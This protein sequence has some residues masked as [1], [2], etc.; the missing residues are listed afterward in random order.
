MPEG[1]K[2]IGARAATIALAGAAVGIGNTPSSSIHSVARNP[3]LAKQLSGHAILGWEARNV[4]MY[5]WRTY[6]TY[7]AGKDDLLRSSYHPQMQFCDPLPMRLA[8]VPLV[9]ADGALVM[10]TC[11]NKRVLKRNEKLRE[12]SLYRNGSSLSIFSLV[13]SDHYKAERAGLFSLCQQARESHF[14]FLKG[15]R[16]AGK[17][18]PTERPRVRV[19]A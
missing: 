17:E 19:C 3:S 16:R 15:K 5:T 18:G 9:M 12:M 13:E 10:V 8:V 11:T 7:P 1:A 2:L 14:H 4:H 6:G